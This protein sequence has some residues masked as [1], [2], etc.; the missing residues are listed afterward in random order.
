M[1]EKNEEQTEMNHR[2]TSLSRRGN[3]NQSLRALACAAAAT[4]I[5]LLS[6]AASADPSPLVQKDRSWISL[7][8]HVVDT[9]VEHFRLD[10]G[11]GLITIEMD[12]WD[13]YD[14]ASDILTGDRVTVYGRI[15]DDLYDNRTIEANSVYSF[16]QNTFHYA[17]DADEEDILFHSQP[18]IPD[19]TRMSLNGTVAKIDGREFV[20]DT[21]ARSM[22]VDTIALG[23]NPL[24]DAG[25]QRISK[26]DRVLVLGRMDV[27]FFE[28]REVQAD[29]IV[30]LS[31]DREKKSDDS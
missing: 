22:R 6:S 11:E 17:N 19:G 25:H 8:G 13:W 28:K 31:R 4:S 29:S 16:G 9:G 26:G 20:L 14:E 27:D 24:D 18:F 15:D 21:G 2:R 30:T 3:P 5:T 7:T 1:E 12:D 23:Y 10:Y